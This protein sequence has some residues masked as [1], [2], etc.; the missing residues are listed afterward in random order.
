[1]KESIFIGLG[2]LLIILFLVSKKWQYRVMLTTQLAIFVTTSFYSFNS[3]YNF[4]PSD[5]KLF[6]WV[7]GE[8]HLVLDPLSVF[9]IFVI[10]LT[11]FTGTLYA[12]GYLKPYQLTRTKIELAWH[13]FNFL[14]LYI[15]MLMVVMLRDGI[16]FLM[17]W[18]LM[19]V[20]TFFLIVFESEKKENKSAG[21]KFIIQMH[22]ALFFLILAFVISSLASGEPLGFESL[23]TYFSSHSAFPLFLIFFIGFGTKAGL[24]PLHTWLPHAHPSAPSHISGVMSGVMIKMGIYGILR[25]LTYIHTDLLAIGIFILVISVISGLVGVILAIVQHDFKQLLAYHS[26]ENIGIIGIGIGV[27]VIGLALNNYILSSLGFAGGLLHVLNHSLFKS[28]LFYSAGS[29]YQQ[30]HTRNIEELGGLMKKMPY[31]AI[32][33]LIGALAISGLPIFN[34]FISEFLIY[35]GL[36]QSFSSNDVLQSVYILG[37]VVALVA[38][39]GLA[40]YCF[41]KVFSIIFLGTPRSD[42]PN[43]ATEV[44]WDMLLPQGL[45]TVFILVIGLFPMLIITPLQSLVGTFVPDTSGLTNMVD[46]MTHVSTVML[47]LVAFSGI[48]FYIRH[49]LSKNKK[50]VIGPTW[51][52]GYTGGNPA[53]VQYTATSYADYIA[54]KG[55]YLVGI[56]KDFKPIEKDVMFPD[57]VTFHTHSTDVFESNLITNPTKKLHFFMSRIAVFQTGN[58]QHYLLYAILF[59]IGIAIVSYLNII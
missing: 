49:V 31:T 47:I 21:I 18:E 7:L 16:S 29:V 17:A 59:V 23:T 42:K 44:S 53:V 5:F 30:T 52:C 6:N 22:I 33:F 50:V 51:G 57:H 46:T 38:I 19:S 35:S 37:A 13:Y 2:S 26:I 12:K 41:T 20:S 54:R 9:F 55:K 48:L 10:N 32:F 11:V 14:V 25:V 3:L 43:H 15:S 8:V 34:G 40:V 36:F 1:M 27:G 39:G 24:I 58:I 45:I 28:L 56:K 4:Q